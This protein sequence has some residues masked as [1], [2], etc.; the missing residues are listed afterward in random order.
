MLVL[1]I[2]GAYS[3]Y[4]KEYF[5]VNFN[6]ITYT[7]EA[8]IGHSNWVYRFDKIIIKNN[9]PYRVINRDERK[10]KYLK[11][12]L[13]KKNRKRLLEFIRKNSDV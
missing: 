1:M 10:I 11:L 8:L 5:T 13:D 9:V 7:V 3:S 6:N 12:L 2:F 4:R